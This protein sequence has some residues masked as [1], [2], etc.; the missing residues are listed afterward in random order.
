MSEEMKNTMEEVE[1]IDVDVT[2]IDE[3]YPD[4]EE[5]EDGSFFKKLALLFGG[6]IIAGGI[7]T[8]AVKKVKPIPKIKAWNEEREIRKLEKKGYT[9]IPNDVIEESKIVSVDDQDDD[10]EE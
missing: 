8:L 2:D 1:T 7:T 3:I 9:V 10:S 5:Y 4:Y 6:S